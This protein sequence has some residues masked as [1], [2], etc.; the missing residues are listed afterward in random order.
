MA[1]SRAKSIYIASILIAA[2]ILSAQAYL[3]FVAAEPSSDNEGP[4][5]VLYSYYDGVGLFLE[6]IHVVA[7]D[8]NPVQGGQRSPVYDWRELY[9][10]RTSVASETQFISLLVSRGDEPTG[11]F[12]I[13]VT[14]MELS[15]KQ[16]LLSA[17]FVDPGEG[18]IVTQAFT[19]PTALVPLG[20]L[21]PGEYSVRLHVDLFHLVA[22]EGGVIEKVP[23][24]TF[25]EVVWRANFTILPAG[26]LP[27][28]DEAARIATELLKRTSTFLFDGLEHTIKVV[29]VQKLVHE[30]GSS[31]P[32][33]YSWVVT[34]D[35]V[36]AHPG[37]GDRS[38]KVLLQVLT[39]HRAVITVSELGVVERAVCDGVWDLV[40]DVEVPSPSPA[41]AQFVVVVNEGRKF[42]LSVDVDVSDG[43]S[44]EEAEVIGERVFVAVLG[45]EVLRRLD[46]ISFEKDLVTIHYTWGYDE[47]DLGHFLEAVV[48]PS[49][50]TIKVT[51]CR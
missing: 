25:M 19:N 18:I 20:R 44:R 38:G 5:G 47:Q 32:N 14:S 41:A 21:P 40:N 48:D 31:A 15:G 12:S 2:I 3:S 13:N 7:T 50:L 30:P 26:E 27:G 10:W 23:I 46:S 37:H 16:V 49:S 4:K 39:S 6:G 33:E 8:A 22:R 28:E 42:D 29:D 1:S 36:T 11:G 24:L 9:R 35:F 17:E 34:I 45:S 43:I 51:H